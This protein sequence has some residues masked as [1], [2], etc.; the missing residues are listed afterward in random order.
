VAPLSQFAAAASR[1]P[2]LL[3]STGK[4]TSVTFKDSNTLT[5]VTTALT[6]DPQQITINNP[7]GETVSLDDAFVAH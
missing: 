2:Q 5:V 1:P 3:R 7:D 4:P 6:P